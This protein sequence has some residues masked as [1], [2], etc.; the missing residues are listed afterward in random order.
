MAE[1]VITIKGEGK[2]S[3]SPDEIHVFFRL[4]SVSLRYEEAVGTV[5]SKYEN[6]LAALRPQG[7]AEG[8]V[9]TTAFSVN[10]EHVSEPDDAGR[11]ISRFVGYRCDHSLK[12]ELPLD[13]PLLG[14]VLAAVSSSG[15]EPETDIRFSVKDAGPLRN[16]ALMSAAENAKNRA[17]LLAKTMGVRLGKLLSINCSWADTPV[18]SGTF[19][20]GDLRTA[21][22]ALASANIVPEDA[23]LSD[24]VT[25]CWEFD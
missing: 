6:L 2:A 8:G 12:V 16:K 21:P 19:T 20:G 22:K 17:E 13:M 4:S 15:A 1:R 7:I 11:Y 25:F 23:E 5:S 3:G 24:T 9:K 14:N 18:Y 10:A